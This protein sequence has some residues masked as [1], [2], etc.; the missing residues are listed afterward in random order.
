MN[1]ILPTQIANM[2]IIIRLNTYSPLSTLGTL[3]NL[4]TLDTSRNSTF[5]SKT[6]KFLVPRR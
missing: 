2:A 3:E 4:D 1:Q 6:R 5:P